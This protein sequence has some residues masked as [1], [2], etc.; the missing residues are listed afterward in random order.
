M[1]SF[2]KIL[3][4]YGIMSPNREKI[5]IE[6]NRWPYD[7]ELNACWPNID[8]RPNYEMERRFTDSEGRL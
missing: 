8:E 4:K 1:I 3:E 5:R 6:F 7:Q 2:P